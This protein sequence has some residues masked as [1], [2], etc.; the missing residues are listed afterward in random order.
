[1]WWPEHRTSWLR[2]GKV[3]CALAAASLAGGCFQP[4]YG[5]RPATPGADTV[6]DKLAEVDIPPINAPRGSP[7]ARVAVELRNELQFNLNNAAGANA[8]VYRLAVSVGSSQITV[9]VDPTSGRPSASVGGVVAS[10]QL[11]EIATGKVVVNDSTYAH[12]DY[13]APGTQQRFASQ[14]ALRDA[15][16]RATTVVADTIRNRLAS[17]FVAG[18]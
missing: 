14:R 15:E 9:I 12:V 1:M 10:Y 4:L 6:H 7:T 5:A 2:L 18:T 16:D 17:Y 13:D 11:I 3:A 8:P